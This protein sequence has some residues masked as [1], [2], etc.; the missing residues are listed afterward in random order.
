MMLIV[1]EIIVEKYLKS[2]FK[3]SNKYTRSFIDHPFVDRFNEIEIIPRI[4]N[5]QSLN[6]NS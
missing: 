5:Y 2:N 6:N 1:I 3:Y 4:S